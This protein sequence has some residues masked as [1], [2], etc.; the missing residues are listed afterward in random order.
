MAVTQVT[1]G[2]NKQDQGDNNWHT[3]LNSGIDDANF[4]LTRNGTDANPNGIIVGYW[5]G[6]RF[7]DTLRV[8]TWVFNGALG[9]NTGWV[10]EIAQGS[11]MMWSGAVGSIPSGW[12]LCDGVLH[13]PTGYTPPD[14]RGRFIVGYDPA[15]AEY[16]AIG[17]V[18]GEKTHVLSV[19]EMPSHNHGGVTGSGAS[20]DAISGI[21]DGGQFG[22]A[23]DTS[24]VHSIPSQ[25]GGAAHENR[26][27]YYTLAYIAK[28]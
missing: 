1:I 18:G 27:P 15:D 6:M 9:A 26:P 19:S 5:K 12:V 3:A 21:N 22:K 4:R 20:A 25:G 11:V 17:D 23:T 16:D 2:L 28:L 13:A 8:A 24:H 10:R 7:F 14:L